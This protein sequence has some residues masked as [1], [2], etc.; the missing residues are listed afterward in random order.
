MDLCYIWIKNLKSH[1]WNFIFFHI[2]TTKQKIIK[3]DNKKM[4][5]VSLVFFF[6][7]YRRHPHSA[8]DC[9]SIHAPSSISRYNPSVST[10]TA[11][12]KITAISCWIRITRGRSC[13][14][15][16]A[17]LPAHFYIYICIHSPICVRACIYTLYL[18]LARA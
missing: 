17:T 11:V 6:F 9:N 1:I 12:L 14:A 15:A 13:Q 7:L 4:T 10:F 3:L 5:D 2:C 16:E 8:A 18:R